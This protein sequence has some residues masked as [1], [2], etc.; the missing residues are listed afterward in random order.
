M[1]EDAAKLLAI[2]DGEAAKIAELRAAAD[3][4]RGLLGTALPGVEAAGEA[5]AYR[6]DEAKGMNLSDEAHEANEADEATDVREEE[7]P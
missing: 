6:A 5:A 7:K 4:L 2:K 3:G 1:A